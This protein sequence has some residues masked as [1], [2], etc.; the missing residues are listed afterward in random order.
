MIKFVSL[1]AL[2][3]LCTSISNAE[4]TPASSIHPKIIFQKNKDPGVIHFKYDDTTIKAFHYY[5]TFDARWLDDFNSGDIFTI[6][7]DR[8]TGVKFIHQKSQ[9]SIKAII[10]EENPI[11]TIQ[12]QC[13]SNAVRVGDIVSCFNHSEQLWK[14]DYIYY[15]KLL[16]STADENLQSHLETYQADWQ[17]VFDTLNDIYFLI[18]ISLRV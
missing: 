15:H 14:A 5:K 8:N 2:F 16:Y 7:I 12:K 4:E 6:K 3:F 1:A 18:M 13:L 17:N 10:Y 9:K 11:E